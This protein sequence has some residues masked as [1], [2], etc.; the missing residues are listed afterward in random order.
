M[1]RKFSILVLSVV[2]G[3]LLVLTALPALAQTAASET[4]VNAGGLFEALRPYI[5]ELVSVIVAFI[6]A[7]LSAKISKLIGMNIE[8]SHRDALQSALQNGANL[9]L[10]K[11]GGYLSS[12]DIDMKNKALAEGVAYVLKSVP[13]A[14]AYF[15]LTPQRIREMV[16]AKLPAQPEVTVLGTVGQI[17]PPTPANG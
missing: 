15:G 11:A 3:S 5:V 9:G 1:I 8:K 12:V 6:V 16:E 4:S 2:V 17:N 14:L 13:D 7:W 10:N